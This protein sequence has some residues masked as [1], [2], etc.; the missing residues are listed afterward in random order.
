MVSHYAV[1]KPGL[2]WEG[3]ATCVPSMQLPPS[4]YT[5]GIVRPQ[6]VGADGWGGYWLLDGTTL[7]TPALRCQLAQIH[8]KLAVVSRRCG[9]G[10]VAVSLW[11]RRKAGRLSM[12]HCAHKH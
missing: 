2:L 12:C 9:E 3:S 6:L 1:E 11:T 5:L 10:A 8:A 4:W 7:A